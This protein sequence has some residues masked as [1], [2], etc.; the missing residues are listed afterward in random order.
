MLS[1]AC[2]QKNSAPL[3]HPGKETPIFGEIEKKLGIIN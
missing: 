2:S 3:P 1:S